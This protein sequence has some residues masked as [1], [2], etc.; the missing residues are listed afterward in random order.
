[1]DGLIW[2]CHFCRSCASAVA[3]YIPG[4]PAHR[5]ARKIGKKDFFTRKNRRKIGKYYRKKGGKQEHNSLI[6]NSKL[7]S[8]ELWWPPLSPAAITITTFLSKKI[9]TENRENSSLTAY[10]ISMYQIPVTRITVL[11]AIRQ[12]MILD[13]HKESINI[14]SW[15][16]ALPNGFTMN[17]LRF[18]T[19]W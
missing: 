8:Y 3:I 4:C 2:Q 13:D 6:W 11:V 9:T 1:M 14:C 15:S 7:L 5:S 16:T 19:Q 10:K 17:Y 18:V 12:C